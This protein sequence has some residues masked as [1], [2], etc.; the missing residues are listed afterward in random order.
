MCDACGVGEYCSAFAKSVKQHVQALVQGNSSR[1]QYSAGQLQAELAVEKEAIDRIEQKRIQRLEQEQERYRAMMERHALEQAAEAEAAKGYVEGSVEMSSGV[2]EPDTVQPAPAV[3][4]EAQPRSNKRR[5][6]N[7][8]Y[9]A[10]AEQL[11]GGGAADAAADG[12][13][14]N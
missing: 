3:E 10:L 2:A 1:A 12:S 6:A 4:E 8:D 7:V 11:F 5:R 14:T 9:S 13:N